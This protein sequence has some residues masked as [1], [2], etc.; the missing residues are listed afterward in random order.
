M[1]AFKPHFVFLD[2]VSGWMDLS[3]A[4]Q[5]GDNPTPHTFTALKYN[6]I[7]GTWHRDMRVFRQ[8]HDKHGMIMG[9]VGHTKHR[10][11]W[12]TIGIDNTGKPIKDGTPDGWMTSIP[13]RGEETIRA[14]FSEIW[15][16][17]SL[18]N[19]AG[20]NPP[21]KLYTQPHLWEGI[22]FDAKSR[23]SIAGP[24]TN[25]TWES[26]MKNLPAGK[27]VPEMILLLGDPGVGKT[28]LFASA[29]S[30]DKPALF[31]DLLGGCE[32]EA[33][34]PYVRVKKFARVEEVFA[35]LKELR[36]TGAV[37]IG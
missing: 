23:K 3:I 8:I 12:K 19:D 17:V 2:S 27:S 13:G 1:A 33:K 9:V 4:G 36:D 6:P 35:L 30:E 26:I 18:P 14:A 15:H 10:E 7:L 20:V 28:T 34:K 16:L 32:E 25:P 29:A 21:R 11:T 22:R 5:V 37:N 24:I 31:L